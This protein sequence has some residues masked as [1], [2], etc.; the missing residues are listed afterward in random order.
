ML[1]FGQP[2]GSVVQQGF[3]V[4]DIHES[5]AQFSRNLGIGPWFLFEPYEF[6]EAQY[7]GQPARMELKIALGFSGHMNIELIQQVNDA[8]SMYQNIAR[9]GGGFHHFGVA[10]V[11]FEEDVE[12]Q[13][14]LG[15][16][17]VFRATNSRGARLAYFETDAKFGSMVEV[18]EFKEA[19]EEFYNKIFEV[20]RDPSAVGAIVRV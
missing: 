9:R 19:Q 7:L 6:R 14:R 8:P 18:I 16:R 12:A 5:M 11:S 20:S 1:K 17:E 2:A 4:T 10:S 15:N 3:I 13:A